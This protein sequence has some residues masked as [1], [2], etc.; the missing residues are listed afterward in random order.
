MD[1]T[2]YRWNTSDIAAD[3]VD[4]EAVII[5]LVD[6]TYYSLD[7]V[8]TVLW[9]SLAAPQS[10]ATLAAAIAGR[11]RIDDARAASD[12]EALVADLVR[13]R[14]VVA[15]PGDAADATDLRDA[16]TGQAGP[17]TTPR[18]NKYT[19]MADMLALDPPLPGLEDLPWKTSTGD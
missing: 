11:Y 5:N 14:L 10:V 4:G 18:L 8:A 2:Q 16:L 15:A 19:D 6:G 12:A 9:E 17:Y 3:V 13:E 1:T 7:L